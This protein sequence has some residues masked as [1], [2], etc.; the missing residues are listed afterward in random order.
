MLLSFEEFQNFI[1]QKD[2]YALFGWPLGHTM[3]PELHTQL[4][5]ASGQ[6]A[7]YIGVAVPPEQ[8]AEA[9]EL[10]KAKLRG[11]NCTIP[12]KKAVIGLL[13]EVD[14]AA[15][16][17]HSVNTV[18][19]RGGKAIGYNTDILGFAES[20]T[21]DGVILSGKKVLLLGYGGAAAVMAYHCAREGASVTITGR[22]LDKAAALQQQIC[23]ALPRAH[24][25]V[26]S[27]KHIPRDIQIVLNSTPL[28]MFPKEEACPLHFLP[29]KTEYVFDAIYNPPVTATMKLANPKKCKT[30]DG[31]FMLVMQAAHAQA[32]WTG[33]AFAPQACETI[34]RRLYGKMAVKRLHDKHGKR[35]IVLCG[36][37]GS[38]KT[39]VGRKL[40]RLTGLPFVD[41]DQYLE[42]KEG[43]PIPDIFAQKGEAY[44]RDRESAYIRE[45]CGRD[46]IVLSLGGGAVLREENVKAIRETGLL[47]HLDTPYF[48]ILKNLSYSDSR[49]LLNK[50]DK[51][52]ETRRLYNA[53]KELYHRVSDVSV[54]SPK[55]SEVLEKVVKSI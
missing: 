17:L 37:M 30:R 20:L 6:D 48:R 51:Q 5:E 46:G 41:A 23:G 4:F 39:T 24:V 2:T 3:S 13:D 9:F 45:L 40:S 25:A 27:R 22:N 38:G 32:I 19:F 18:A 16:D 47:I 42:A 8:L 12:H 50:P 53:R 52:A 14:N 26:F 36:F 35:N 15:R 55:I 31:L 43:Q 54:R 44:F 7:D 49:P 29:R 1:P 21:R 11:I 28:G 33:T 34:L 10:A